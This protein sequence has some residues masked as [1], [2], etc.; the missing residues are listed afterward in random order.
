MKKKSATSGTRTQD[1]HSRLSRPIMLATEPRPT[2]NQF[3]S[4]TD[5]NCWWRYLSRYRK[6]PTGAH[7]MCR[8]NPFFGIDRKHHLLRD[9]AI[10]GFLHTFKVGINTSVVLL[11][12]IKDFMRRKVCEKKPATSGTR[13]QDSHSRLSR[14]SCLPLSRGPPATN[15]FH[16]LILTAG[17]DTCF[18]FW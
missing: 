6:P 18:Q 8:Q 1:S 4:Q 14:P 16:R 3:L 2:S 5:I 15:S 9:E 10:Q 11:L 13:T 12:R 17:G 7:S